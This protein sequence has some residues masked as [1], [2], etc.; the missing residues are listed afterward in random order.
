MSC[1]EYFKRVRNIV[2]VI[3]NLGGLLCDDMHLKD[4]L[5]ERKP[6]NGY[7]DDQKWEARE[8]IHNKTMAYGILVRSDRTHFGRLIE[9]VENN[10]L[11]GHDNYPKTATEAYNLLVNYKNYGNK[12]NKRSAATGLDQVAFMAKAKRKNQME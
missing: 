5:H 12:Q 8:Q 4:E 11:K 10:Y 9:E 6:R 2:D 3:K 1:Q 7:T